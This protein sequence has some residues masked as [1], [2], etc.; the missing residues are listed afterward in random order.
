MR[1]RILLHKKARPKAWR[2]VEVSTSIA[3]AIREQRGNADM[4]IVDCLS[5]LVANLI[6]P[7][8]NSREVEEVDYD[9]VEKELNNDLERIIA[10]VEELPL[11]I[12]IV[13]NEVGM[14]LVPVYPV[15]RAY[16]DL[17]GRANQLIARNA[18]K[19]YLMVAGIPLQ[20]K[21]EETGEP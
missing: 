14:G 1:Q 8:H 19:V 2:T 9:A 10:L 18:D 12:I 11:Q 17:L 5:M 13:S 21:G 20:L 15:G 4:V 6:S 16:R 3:Q 7:I